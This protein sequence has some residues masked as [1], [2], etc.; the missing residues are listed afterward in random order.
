MDKQIFKT[1][2]EILARIDLA[3]MSK[4]PITGDERYALLSG[5]GQLMAQAGMAQAVPQLSARMLAI[6]ELDLPGFSYL[7]KDL[8][9]DM[10]HFTPIFGP[11][12]YEMQDEYEYI[13]AGNIYPNEYKTMISNIAGLCTKVLTLP[14]NSRAGGRARRRGAMEVLSEISKICVVEGAKEIFLECLKEKDED[15]WMFALDGLG[16]YWYAQNVKPSAEEL[17]L[18]NQIFNKT[19]DRST[20]STCLQVQIDLGLIDEMQALGAMDAWKDR[21]YGRR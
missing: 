17:A 7:E 9:H 18:I 2:D 6:A 4:T 15:A 13:E 8:W 10:W 3:I 11:A 21:V 20:A 5:L 1:F 19:K 16:N 14:K 12:D